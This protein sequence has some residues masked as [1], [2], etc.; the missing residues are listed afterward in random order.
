[1][2]VLKQPLARTC[3]EQPLSR[4][5][6]GGGINKDEHAIVNI[7]NGEGAAVVTGDWRFRCS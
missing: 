2:L 7:A 5:A 1:M 6:R 3:T 4:K